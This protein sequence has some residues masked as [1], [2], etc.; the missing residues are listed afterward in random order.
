MSLVENVPATVGPNL[1]RTDP[2]SVRS[3]D[4]G[5]AARH[6][7][8][9]HQLSERGRFAEAEVCFRRAIELGPGGALAYNNLGWVRSMQGAPDEAIGHYEKAL[10]LDAGLRIARRNLATLLVRLG[11][12]EQ[13]LPLWH[14]EMQ[15]GAEGVAWINGLIASGMRDRDLTLAGEYAAILAALRWGSRG[16][17]PFRDGSL[18]PPALPAAAHFLTGP[19]LLHDIAQFSYLQ[20]RGVLGDEFTPIINHYRAIS[21]RLAPHGSNARVPLEGEDRQAI[22]H[23]YNRIVHIRHTPRVAK[24]LSGNWNAAA[25]EKAYLD[26]R[27]GVVVVDD[28]LASEALESVRLFCLESTVWSANRYAHGRLGAFF[29]DGFNCPLLLQIAE[30]LRS[31][32]PRIIGDLYPLRQLW[33]FKNAQHLP[34][35]STIHADFA[36]VNVNFWITPD[37]ANLDPRSGGLVVYGVDA[38]LHWDFLTYNGRSDII[39]PFL[40]RQEAR[41]ITIP[42]KQNRAIIFNSDLFHGTE[43]VNFRPEY[44]NRRINITMLYGER[45]NDIHHRHLARPDHIGGYEANPA[46]WRS[47]AFARGRTARR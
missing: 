26:R 32:L 4:A 46:G 14:Q 34:G 10:Q 17:L 40:Q 19:K 45:E 24:A 36:A 27:P 3:D 5:E 28:F 2:P 30:E 29:H 31:A 23:V 13:S 6:L 7:A 9:G 15:S 42:Y 41:S 20:S 44:E 39:K 33:G 22:G 43:E 11:R 37:D 21:D 12:R 16:N 18:A 1:I 38:P 25:V 8:R 35:D 47:A